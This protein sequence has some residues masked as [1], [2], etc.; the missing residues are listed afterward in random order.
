MGFWSSFTSIIV[1]T[2]GKTSVSGKRRSNIV[3]ADTANSPI[4]TAAEE[5]P[6]DRASS[7]RAHELVSI[8]N[9]HAAVD[10]GSALRSIEEAM[11]NRLAKKRAQ[12]QGGALTGW[13]SDSTLGVSGGGGENGTFPDGLLLEYVP[14]FTGTRPCS[15][16]S[17]P[18]HSPRGSVRRCPCHVV[19]L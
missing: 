6:S 3:E 10:D 1:V 2:R 14:L 17:K 15:Q 19:Y 13:P 5:I 12:Q 16:C 8:D 4:I 18:V 9:G 7:F 11:S